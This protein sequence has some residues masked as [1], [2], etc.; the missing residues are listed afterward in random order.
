MTPSEFLIRGKNLKFCDFFFKKIIEKTV[1]KFFDQF[2]GIYAKNHPKSG[3]SPKR[4]LMRIF[5]KIKFEYEISNSRQNRQGGHRI[6][7]SSSCF[8]RTSI[9]HCSRN[10]LDR[11]W[12]ENPVT[13]VADFLRLRKKCILISCC[14]SL[15]RRGICGECTNSERAS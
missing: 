5:G 9:N 10:Q 6:F 4:Y 8:L 7:S 2:F 15:T 12:S 14:G 1:F 13:F 11:R 3:K